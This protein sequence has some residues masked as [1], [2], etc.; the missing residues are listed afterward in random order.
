MCIYT[1]ISKTNTEEKD[2]IGE[3]N[4]ADSLFMIMKLQIMIT[5]QEIK[6]I[7]LN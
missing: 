1:K 2:G 5:R 7:D 3:D 4:I 6:V